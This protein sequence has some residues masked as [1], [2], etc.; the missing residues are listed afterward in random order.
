MTSY[1][2]P[3]SPSPSFPS[4]LWPLLKP[5]LVKFLFPGGG[6]RAG[7]GDG[8]TYSTSPGRQHPD[9][10]DVWRGGGRHCDVDGGRSIWCRWGG[11]GRVCGVRGTAAALAAAPGMVPVVV[12]T[13][14]AAVPEG[15]GAAV[16]TGH[17]FL[18]STYVCGGS[19]RPAPL[20]MSGPLCPLRPDAGGAGHHGE[21]EGGHKDSTP[22]LPLPAHPTGRCARRPP[23]MSRPL[24]CVTPTAREGGTLSLVPHSEQ[25]EGPG[26][27]Q[28]GGSG[29]A[30]SRPSPSP[31]RARRWPPPRRG[32]C[33]GQPPSSV[34]P[35]IGGGMGGWH[36]S[37]HIT[38]G[39][40]E[41]MEGAECEG[42]RHAGRQHHHVISRSG[43]DRQRLLPLP[44]CGG[45]GEEQC[46]SWPCIPPPAMTLIR[47]GGA[48]GGDQRGRQGR[49]RAT[50]G[51]N[52][53]A[54]RCSVCACVGAHCVRGL[55]FP[56][57]A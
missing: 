10:W 23:L 47:G 17:L 9:H 21:D 56:P 41:A 2:F 36:L 55:V 40:C 22:A 5:S 11:S 34:M 6:G 54:R 31:R 4:R 44:V 49:G 25:D 37:A 35:N 24:P 46:H 20:R 19:R 12:A 39:A 43:G 29:R 32:S 13:G 53:G 26:Y 1:S 57:P 42:G 7:G 51:R 52:G 14:A 18:A 28:S 50:R 48:G 8:C 27:A 16:T 45:D 33:R 3:P 15:G 38:H 30:F